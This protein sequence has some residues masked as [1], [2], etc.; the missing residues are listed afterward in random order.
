MHDYHVHSNY[1]DGAF[2]PGMVEAAA[3]AGLDGIGIADHC[4]VSGREHLSEYKRLFGFNLDE[5]YERRR[6]AIETLQERHDVRVYDA[7]E[8]DY[9]PDDEA[10]IRDFLADA[11]FEYAVGSVHEIDEQNV[12]GAY[13]ADLSEADQRAAVEEYFES[14]LALV[15]SGLFD[16][17]AHADI[18]ERNPALRGYATEDHYR[19]VAEAVADADVVPELNAGRVDEEYGEFH[20]APDFLS[21]LA[22]YD[23]PVTVGS[24]AHSP[25]ALRRRQPMLEERLTEADVAVATLSLD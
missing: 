6:K 17:L 3:D 8:M 18:V 13:F 22:E 12:H 14:L 24:D 7:V 15:E 2:L 20:P 5:T 11:G 16:V 19:A 25:E 10:A 21:I 4:N 9:H 1:S 23:I